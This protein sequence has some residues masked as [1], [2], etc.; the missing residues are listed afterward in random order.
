[1]QSGFD[2]IPT[3]SEALADITKDWSAHGFRKVFVKDHAI[4]AWP[5]R[6]PHDVLC[7]ARNTFIIRCPSKAIKSLYRQ[8]LAPFEESF[9]D[10][11]VPHEVGYKEQWLMLDLIANELQQPVLVID[12]DDLMADPEAVLTA[13]C[14]FAG[15]DFADSML[16]C[17]DAEKADK[18][19]EFIPPS[20]M[21]D[22]VHTTGFRSQD[23]V[24]DA[25]PDG[26]PQIVQDTIQ[27][28]MPWCRKLYAHK[29]S[30]PSSD[31]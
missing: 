12:A 17:D 15:L 21:R 14:S 7:A 10:R 31:G 24:H 26:Y 29:L 2:K 22:M 25:G 18:P 28:S 16:H 19:W 20:W 11:L 9:W 3:P 30:L 6:V 23:K 1:M 27:E 13:Y 5:D 8:T 4:Y